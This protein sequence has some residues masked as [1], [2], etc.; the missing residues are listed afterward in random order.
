MGFKKQQKRPLWTRPAAIVE[1][2]RQA[3]AART[4]FIT[5]GSGQALVYWRKGQ[6]AR[7]CLAAHD[8]QNPPAAGKYPA[9][10]AE[11]G[12]TGETVL[13]VAQVIAD[14]EE[15]WAQVADAIETIRLAAKRAVEDAPA[16]PQIAA[17]I[18]GLVWPAPE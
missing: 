7:E 6:Q 9:L 15:G 12:I 14:I 18:E 2:D 17:V 1:I 3:E 10:E 5:A 11:V 4:R 13:A 16:P 8:A